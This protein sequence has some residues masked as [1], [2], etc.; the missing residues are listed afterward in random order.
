MARKVKFP[1]H[2]ANGADVRTLEDLKANFD[3]T[4]V[5][6]YY[7]TGKLLTWLRDRYCDQEAA[8]VEEIT[9]DMNL[10][11]ELC[12]IFG[13][14]MKEEAEEVDMEFVERRKQKKTELLQ[15]GATKELLDNID[16][17][18]LNQDDLIDCLDGD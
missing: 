6:E 15:L 4:S 10:A 16:S 5:L 14:D 11:K 2:M 3:L 9:P 18:A 8:R 1:L 7:S 13:I 12:N 17:V